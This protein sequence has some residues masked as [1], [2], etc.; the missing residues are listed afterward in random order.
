[1]K[2]ST[3]LESTVACKIYKMLPCRNEILH[4]VLA[5]YKKMGLNLRL[6]KMPLF[7]VLSFR[8]PK[9]VENLKIISINS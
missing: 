2:L 6:G 7:T 8:T 1:M 4:A 9:S 3:H 5:K